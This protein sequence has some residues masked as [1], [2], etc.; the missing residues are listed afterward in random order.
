MKIKALTIAVFAGLSTASPVAQNELQNETLNLASSPSTI[1]IDLS[2][3]ESWD[4]EGDT[5]SNYF[6]MFALPP[7]AQIIGVGW[8]IS[9]ETIGASWLSEVTVSFSNTD[10]SGIFYATPGVGDD[11]PGTA[12]YSSGGKID[13]VGAG[14]DFALNAD[15]M[16]NLEVF[17][18]F[19][20]V[21]DTVDAVFGAGSYFSIVYKPIPTPGSLALLGLGG[22]AAARRRR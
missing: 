9:I 12:S 6:E 18:T 13:L 1:I 3:V 4:L 19:D 10:G 7:G 22:L 16:L 8:E 2:G 14:L 20:D 21:A 17:E 11:L 5:L 15:G